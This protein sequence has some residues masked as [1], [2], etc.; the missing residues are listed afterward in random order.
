MITSNF[1]ST[2]F[3]L[4]IC[5]LNRMPDLLKS[6]KNKFMEDNI[7]NILVAYKL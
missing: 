3:I 6:T 1:I 5:N 2:F 7:S 4:I